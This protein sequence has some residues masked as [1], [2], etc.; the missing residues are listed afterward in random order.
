ML[1][2]R[3]TRLAAEIDSRDAAHH[4]RFSAA[5]AYDDLVQRRIHE[6]R[7]NPG[8]ADVSRVHG[9]T[10]GSGHEHLARSPS[11]RMRSP[12]AWRGQPSCSPLGST[13]PASARI[14]RCSSR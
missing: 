9:A 7:E 2:D 13:S 6:L 11:V 4:F 10:L 1:L 3:L 14:A 5:M 8:T 12:A